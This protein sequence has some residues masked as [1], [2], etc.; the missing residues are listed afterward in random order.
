MIN[1]NDLLYFIELTQT[2]HVSRAAERLGVT[3]PTLSH[4]IK[5]LEK[6]VGT[7]LFIRT[8]KGIELTPAAERLRQSSEELIMKWNEVLKAATDEVEQAKGLIKLGIHTAVAQYVLPKIIPPFLKKYEEIQFSF[9]HGLSRHITEM[10]ITS[11]LDVGFVVNP[12]EHPDLVIKELIQDRAT[13]W[14]SKNAV[15]NDVLIVEPSLLQTQNLIARM[16]K[17]GI[18]FKRTIESSSL[19]VIAQLVNAGAGAAILPERVMKAFCDSSVVQIKDAPE[20][21][22]RICLVYQQKFRKLKRGNI[23][24]EH[25]KSSYN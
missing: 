16:N 7:L 15:S 4:C 5:R 25:V 8:K 20:F 17:K 24:V 9:I 3:Q 18:H 2:K 10:I 14:K 12:V 13:I 21:V 22:D 6:S 23:F 19:E 1:Q 11:Q